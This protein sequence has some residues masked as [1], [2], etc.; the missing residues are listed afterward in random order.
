MEIDFPMV[1]GSMFM[2]EDTPIVEAVRAGDREAFRILVERHQDKVFSV[3]HRITNDPDRVEELAQEAFMRAYQGI[4]SFRGE[5]QFGTWLVQIAVYAARDFN[6]VTVTVRMLT[7]FLAP[8]RPGDW[9]EGRAS[10]TRETKSFYFGPQCI[11]W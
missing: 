3:L 8:A 10:L 6:K 7:D 4:Q 11:P 1:E 9:V 5:S 2:H